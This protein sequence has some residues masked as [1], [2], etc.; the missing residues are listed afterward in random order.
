MDESSAVIK[1]ELINTTFSLFKFVPKIKTV[2]KIA[3]RTFNI[4]RF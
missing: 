4:F 2:N 1:L 3:I